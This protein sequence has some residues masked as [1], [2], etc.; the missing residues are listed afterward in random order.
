M[1]GGNY[2]AFLRDQAGD[3]SQPGEIVDA[4]GTVLGRHNGIHEFTVGQRKGLGLASAEPRYVLALRPEENV[5]VVGRREDALASGLTCS[6]L[7]FTGAPPPETFGAE[8]K[9]RYRTP[10]R[11]A[12]VA[13]D[14]DTATVR[15][16]QPMWGVAPGQL[17]VFYAG[18][19]VIGGGT[20]DAALPAG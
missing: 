16:A 20:I 3:L 4:A 9:V 12:T 13:L 19:R 15:F 11:Q 10:A 1:A 8:V 6:R 5:V 17:A 7:S 2:R 18:G 14:G